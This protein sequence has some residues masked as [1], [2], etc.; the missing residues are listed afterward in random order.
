MKRISQSGR[1]STGGDAGSTPPTLANT[2]TPRRRALLVLFV[3]LVLLVLL[4]A[5][6]DTVGA[7]SVV[8]SP[9]A[10]AGKHVAE[11]AAEARARAAAEA[12]YERPSWIPTQKRLMH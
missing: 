2:L 7:G 3:A 9:P 1:V 10:G 12:D 4:Y 5:L 6:R 8:Q 11:A